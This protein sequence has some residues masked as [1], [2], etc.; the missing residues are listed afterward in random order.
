MNKKKALTKIITILLNKKK[1]NDR[2]NIY[3]INRVQ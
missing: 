1:E 2:G 3:N